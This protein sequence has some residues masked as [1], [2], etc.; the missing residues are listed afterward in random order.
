MK[1][2]GEEKAKNFAM[3]PSYV[4]GLEFNDKTIINELGKK[5]L[6][7][8]VQIDKLENHQVRSRNGLSHF[9]SIFFALDYGI[10]SLKDFLS[11][12]DKI[13]KKCNFDFEVDVSRQS[14]IKI[15]ALEKDSEVKLLT[16][17]LAPI[18]GRGIHGYKESNGR[19]K[20]SLKKQ[21]ENRR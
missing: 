8:F 21:V 4:F 17:Y 5:F 20:T 11:I 2:E 10:Q 14:P 6:R 13:G 16:F 7:K 15:T 9:T 3:N 1:I 18:S 19:G 12:I